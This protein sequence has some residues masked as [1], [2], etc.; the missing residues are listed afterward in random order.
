MEMF[1]QTTVSTRTLNRGQPMWD[2]THVACQEFCLSQNRSLAVSAA[3]PGASARACTRSASRTRQGSVYRRDD[4]SPEESSEEEGQDGEAGLAG[5]LYRL[6]APWKRACAGL[7][8]FTVLLL[9]MQMLFPG[10]HSVTVV[11]F[12][13]A[14]EP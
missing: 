1:S 2:D 7:I 6:P 11:T 8:D 14:I 3:G 4:V 10:K 12:Y 5:T 9:C 13:M